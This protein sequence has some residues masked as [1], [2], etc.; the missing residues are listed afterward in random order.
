M[1]MQRPTF[2]D[3]M[4]LSAGMFFENGGF[5]RIIQ[6]IQLAIIMIGSNPFIG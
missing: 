4:N 3:V 2:K 5:D 6:N 1:T